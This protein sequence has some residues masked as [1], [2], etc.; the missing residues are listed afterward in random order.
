MTQTVHQD[1]R[2]AIA[3][4]IHN[5]RMGWSRHV[6]QNLPDGLG[7]VRFEHHHLIGAYFAGQQ[8]KFEIAAAS[9]SGLP[10]IRL[11]AI[12]PTSL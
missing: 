7:L 10:K 4:E 6:S 9:K 5:F 8:I 11:D 1:V 3:I 12:G 2:D